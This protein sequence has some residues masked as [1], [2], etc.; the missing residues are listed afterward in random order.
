MSTSRACLR[1]TDWG[2]RS[3]P[4]SYLVCCVRVGARLWAAKAQKTA[5]RIAAS[6]PAETGPLANNK[7]VAKFDTHG[8]RQQEFG[9][10]WDLEAL[11]SRALR[12]C[13]STAL[14]VHVDY[15][16]IW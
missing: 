8:I 10:P 15:L 3:W 16:C 14:I 9:G 13:P 7:L 4:A 5:Q 12:T 6:L 2:F 1:G 11:F